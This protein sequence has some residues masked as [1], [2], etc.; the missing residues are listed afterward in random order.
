MI[1][2]R[3]KQNKILSSMKRDIKILQFKMNHKNIEKIKNEISRKGKITFCKGRLYAPYVIAFSLSVGVFKTFGATPFI[4]DRSKNYQKVMKEIDACNNIKIIKQFDDFKTTENV[5][6]LY[7]KWVKNNDGYTRAIK[8]YKLDNL[9]D[10]GIV[11]LLNEDINSIEEILGSPISEKVEIRN[12]I[13]ENELDKNSYLS[14]RIYSEDKDEFIFINETIKKNI[15][16]TFFWLIT[17]LIFESFA[18]FYRFFSSFS[19][20]KM[21]KK[22][23]DMYSI[24]KFDIIEKRL[25]ILEINYR[26]ISKYNNYEIDNQVISK[27]LNSKENTM[28]SK[29]TSEELRDVLIISMETELKYREKLTYSDDYTDG[30][31]I[32]LENA[33]VKLINNSLSKF[34]SLNWVLTRDGSLKKGVEIISPIMRDTSNYW[35]EL[36][37]VCNLINNLAFIDKHCGLHV[38]CGAHILGRSE[39]NW[40][41]FIKLFAV[42]ENILFRFAYGEFYNYRDSI[43]EFAPPISKQLWKDYLFLKEKNADLKEILYTIKHGKYNAINFD[44]VKYDNVDKVVNGNTVEIRCSNGSKNP[45]IIQNYINLLFALYRYACSDNFNDEILDKRHEM[46][47]DIYDNIEIYNDIYLEQALELIDLVFDNNLDKVYFLNQYLKDFKIDKKK[48]NKNKTFT[49]KNKK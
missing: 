36:Y 11:K 21:I 2:K 35:N 42:Y 17:F 49:K 20:K 29:L 38:H 34:K 30:V 23:N 3:K 19:Y 33:N 18:L 10:D 46:C 37:E 48:F 39:K 15:L 4:I 7:E 5:I 12:N 32:E 8:V 47:V 44:H 41:N 24:D 6:T 45:I 14:A 1:F 25:K 43:M 28:F 27:Y 16:D 40:L 22:I 9:S 13:C 31:E 26:I